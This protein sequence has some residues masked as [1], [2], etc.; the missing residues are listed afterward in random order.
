MTA[1]TEPYPEWV[2]VHLADHMEADEQLR[3]LTLTGSITAE[4]AN[5]PSP[6]RL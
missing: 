3:H 6:Y 2:P 1:E 5:W 4:D